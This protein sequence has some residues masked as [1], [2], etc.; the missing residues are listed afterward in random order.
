MPIKVKSTLLGTNDSDNTVVVY[1]PSS[2][3]T[4]FEGIATDAV[5]KKLSSKENVIAI[6]KEMK[7]I[8]LWKLPLFLS[9]H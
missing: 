4:L 5:I 6:A 8:I 2:L 9:F 3:R 7:A 1:S